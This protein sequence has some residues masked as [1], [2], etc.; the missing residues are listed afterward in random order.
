LRASYFRNKKIV[1]PWNLIQKKNAQSFVATVI[2]PPNLKLSWSQRASCLARR[3]QGLPSSM[4][5]V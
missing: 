5:S 2:I 1:A 3:F 4:M